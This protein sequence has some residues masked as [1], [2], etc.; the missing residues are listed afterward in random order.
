M[1]KAKPAKRA[2]KPAPAMVT[3]ALSI[4]AWRPE[5]AIWNAGKEAWEGRP[6][7]EFAT[8][9]LR[10]TALHPPKLK[11]QPA[12]VHLQG[13]RDLAHRLGSPVAR[14]GSDHEPLGVAALTW[15]EGRG[16]LLWSPPFDALPMITQWLSIG[17][18]KYLI[19]H[20]EPLRYGRAMLRSIRLSDVLDEDEL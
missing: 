12:V 3:Y 14:T 9:E 15:R 2:A 16:Q 1:P 17:R 6:H 11:G 7:H 5:Y 13:D 10:T 20:G 18:I 8:V 19:G 4:D